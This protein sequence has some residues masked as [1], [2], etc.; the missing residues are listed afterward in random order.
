M[1]KEKDLKEEISKLLESSDCKLDNLIIWGC[2]LNFEIEYSF[3]MN[4]KGKQ[5]K[6]K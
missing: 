2:Y 6:L 5:K 3:H 4:T 1:K